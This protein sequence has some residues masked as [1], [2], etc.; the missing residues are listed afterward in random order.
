MV[1]ILWALVGG[2]IMFAGT[3]GGSALVFLFRRDP[4]PLLHTIF[5]GLAAGIMIAAS[6][7]SLLMPAME[8]EQALR[9][10]SPS[11]L[12]AAV[13][14]LI[15][16]VLLLFIDRLLPHAHPGTGAT[17]G[18]RTKLG[19]RT[20]LMLAVTLHNVPEGFAAGL[21]FAAAAAPR[22][23]EIVSMGAALM[24]AVGLCIQNVPEGAALSLPLRD[25]GMSS[26]QAFYYGSMSGV[27]EPIAAVVAAVLVDLLS[28]WMPWLLSIAAG[29]MM[30]VV[31]EELVPE[32]HI[33][34]NTH[35]GT[36]SLI[37]GFVLM[38]LLDGAS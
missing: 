10:D 5:L 18:I 16:A 24:L 11:W 29:A 19:K 31:A 37:V 12:P 35:A 27:V 8:M 30:Y 25:D 34:E 26:A 20:M 9:P 36:M 38:M 2:L 13:G 21:M 17:E 4:S 28:P 3:A 15:G 32:S 23:G 22:S 7:W 6:V 1:P 33:E 14:L